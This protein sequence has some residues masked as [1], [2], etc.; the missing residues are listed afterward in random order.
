MRSL[1]NRSLTVRKVLRLL[2]ISLINTIRMNWFY[3][4]WKGV[5]GGYIIAAKNLKILR[6]DGSLNFTTCPYRGILQIGFSSNGI[7]DKKYERSMWGN[8]GSINIGGTVKL[9]QGARLLNS[10]VI[11]FSGNYSM[12]N[13]AIVCA[14]EI[15]FGEDVLVSWDDLI[16]DCDFHKIY[17]DKFEQ[18]QVNTS[19][20]LQLATMFG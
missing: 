16:M 14:N 17:N 6:L 9:L 15:L 2:E 8:T 20:K 11:T 18:K 7:F 19:K 10:G 3:F 12:G 4:G 5:L 13:S 1:H